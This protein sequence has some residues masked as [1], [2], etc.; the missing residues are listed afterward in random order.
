MNFPT[1]LLYFSEMKWTYK[2]SKCMECFGGGFPGGSGGKESVCNARDL[3]LIPGWG[4]FHGKGNGNPLQYSCLGNLMDRGTWWS[5]V[6]GVE[7]SQTQGSN[8]HWLWSLF[9]KSLKGKQ[10]II[11]WPFP[12]PTPPCSFLLEEN[13]CLKI[14]FWRLFWRFSGSSHSPAEGCFQF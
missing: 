7:K 14:L 11:L 10:V 1:G 9:E 4:S 8:W 2:I 5:T 12:F 13:N 6:H 3:G